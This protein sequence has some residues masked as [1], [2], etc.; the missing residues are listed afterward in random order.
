MRIFVDTSAFY[1]IWDAGD[2]SHDSA[3]KILL[4]LLDEDQILTSS[5]IISETLTLISMRIGKASATKFYNEI[6]FGIETIVL[7]FETYN[8]SID[9]FKIIKS[10]NVSF[11]DCTSFVICKK[12]KIDFAFSFDVH[13]KKQGIKILT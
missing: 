8:E 3:I 5:E 7:D 2:S 6:L 4:G 9:L 11:V 10:K 13:F 1:A 12:N